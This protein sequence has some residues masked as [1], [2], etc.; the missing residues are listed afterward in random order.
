MGNN[1][2]PAFIT[3]LAESRT[4]PV[5]PRAGVSGTTRSNRRRLLG[6]GEGRQGGFQTAQTIFQRVADGRGD[7]RGRH[8]HRHRRRA[9]AISGIGGVVDT[10]SAAG[11]DSGGLLAPLAWASTGGAI[12]FP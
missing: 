1:Q 2:R 3:R 6:F 7:L 4:I 8:Q 12:R 5:V 11:A 10:A 9:G